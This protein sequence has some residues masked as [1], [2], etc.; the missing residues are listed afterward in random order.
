M[1]AKFVQVIVSPTE[2]ALRKKGPVTLSE[3]ETLDLLSSETGEESTETL[4]LLGGS[5]GED[6]GDSSEEMLWLG[7]GDTNPDIDM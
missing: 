4:L 7:I 5:S 3:P 2:I 1:L 6:D